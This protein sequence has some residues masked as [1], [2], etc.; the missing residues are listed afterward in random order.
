MTN[1]D[2]QRVE[3]GVAREHEKMIWRPYGIPTVLDLENSAYHDTPIS[4]K[5]DVP[6]TMIVSVAITGAFFQHKQ[7]PNQPITPE[8]I[9]ESARECALAG[10]SSI[11]IHVRDDDGFN[12]LSP[13]RFHEVIAPLH[14]EF[15]TMAI[16]GC[17][18][19]AL[20]GEWAKMK[21]VLDSGL[22]DAAPV[23]ATATYIGDSLFVKPAPILMEKTR[24]I[25]ACGS[26]PEIAVYTDADVS[27][28]DRFLLKSGLVEPG[29]VWVVLPG[30]PGGSPMDNTRQMIEG[31]I[32]MVNAIRDV[33]P[34][35]VLVVCTAG[36]A[37]M[38]VATLAALMGLHIR[39]GMED[40][41]FKWPHR[42]DRL[43]SNLEALRLGQQI[44]EVV[45]RR[46]ATPEE[47][48]A[49]MGLPPVHTAH[50]TT[51]AA[52]A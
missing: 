8:E 47:T 19:P 41:Y 30:L 23:N 3:A 15:P 10:A 21:E 28:A 35:G 11:H 6:E 5:W 2:W 1:V 26:K 13:E 43:T 4:Q 12:V 34:T 45:G 42:D 36:R 29:A 40:T 31:L 39:V 25:N 46:V 32:R 33:D 14:D 9:R 20:S 44:A 50:K 17:L 51:A 52:G 22:L 16:D 27:N 49:I 18:V 24:L 7:N 38:H 48:R 37:A